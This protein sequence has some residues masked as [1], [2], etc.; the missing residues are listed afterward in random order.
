[1]FAYDIFRALSAS[2]LDYVTEANDRT[3]YLEDLKTAKGLYRER[4][5]TEMFNAYMDEPLAIRKDVMNYVNMIIGIDAENLGRQN[6]E[7]QRPP[8]RGTQGPEGGRTLYQSVEERLGL[9]TEE[10][11]ESFRPPSAKYT[12]R[13]YPWIRTTILWTTWNWSRRLPMCAEI[14]HCRRRQPDRCAG[15]PHQR[16]EPEAL[17]PHDRYHAQ[18]A[19]LLPDLCPEDHR[20]FLYPRG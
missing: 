15:Q 3:K 1:M 2:I 14:G 6:V 17:R 13:R 8:D 12:A 9:K 4:I 19:E 5:M 16:G 18:Q 10:Q 7:I 11:R 20:V